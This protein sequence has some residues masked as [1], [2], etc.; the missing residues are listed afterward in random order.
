LLK[1]E[2]ELRKE[3]DE[4]RARERKLEAD[5]KANL[6]QQRCDPEVEKIVKEIALLDRSR[7]EPLCEG[8]QRYLPRE[9]RDVIYGYFVGPAY[10]Y[11]NC[12]KVLLEKEDHPTALRIFKLTSLH[13]IVPDI[14]HVLASMGHPTRQELVE[15]WYKTCT[16][17]FG[18]DVHLIGDFLKD[19]AAGPILALHLVRYLEITVDC[20]SALAE[21]LEY[22]SLLRRPARL[23]I[24]LDNEFGGASAQ[25]A[26]LRDV[27]KQLAQLL[28]V[29]A[30][31]TIELAVNIITDAQL[32][33]Y[34]H[35]GIH[36]Q[37]LV[38][39]YDT[40]LLVHGGAEFSFY[41]WLESIRRVRDDL[42][43]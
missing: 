26:Q 27:L 2:Q 31:W 19:D 18:I 21:A 3:L 20:V 16:F 36:N 28:P 35:S 40:R 29:L 5:L 13:T 34:E 42:V 7:R 32:N 38:R 39:G 9:L 41:D 4:T 22:L 23:R 33:A 25:D 6:I 10:G 37:H 24:N 14:G 1:E 8:M 15:Y 17:D 30:G 43:V 12:H 11:D